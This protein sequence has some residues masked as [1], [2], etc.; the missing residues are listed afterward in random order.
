MF[1]LVP[2]NKIK[3]IA[4]GTGSKCIGKSKMS[5][6]GSVINDSHAEV[7]ARRSFIRYLYHELGKVYRGDTSDVFTSFGLDGRCQ[8]KNNVAF[9]FYTSHT[10][11]GDASIFPKEDNEDDIKLKKSSKRCNEDTETIDV[12]KRI[13]I[14]Q[15]DASQCGTLER[16]EKEE[17][18]IELENVV[19]AESQRREMDVC[20]AGQGGNGK[21]GAGNQGSQDLIRIDIATQRDTIPSSPC[22]IQREMDVL[23]LVSEKKHVTNAKD[24]YRTGAK[25]LPDGPQDPGTSGEGYHHVGILRT[26]PG[27]GDRTL[28]MSCSDKIAKW[29]VIGCQG[30]LLSHLLVQPVYFD[31]ITVGCCVYSKPAMERAVIT[32]CDGVSNLPR[33]YRKHRPRLLYSDKV[34]PSSKASMERKH[35]KLLGKLTP[36]GSA[37]IWCDIPRNNLEVSVNGFKQGVI[38]KSL[39]SPKARCSV[40]KAEMFSTFKSLVESIPITRRPDT[41]RCSKLDTYLEYK[42]AA[43]EYQ[44]AWKSVQQVFTTWVKKPKNYLE[45][46]C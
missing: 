24:I 43:S 16:C 13:K 33:L 40:C 9:H 30:A 8:V 27:R 15:N 35:N 11:C 2:G 17:K 26:K 29:N 5:E 32:R 34:F 23:P 41:L 10:P 6:K 45:F 21:Q 38:A 39:D 44:K 12:T 4:M 46:S 28:S 1:L 19:C 37:I 20:Y 3:V 25:C 7:I 42:E 18:C 36:C 31:T 14:S 22:D